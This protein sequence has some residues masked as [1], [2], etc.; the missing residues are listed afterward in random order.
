MSFC[1]CPLVIP[2][3]D[4]YSLDM[5]YPS[6]SLWFADS[7]GFTLLFPRL[8][9]EVL[10]HVTVDVLANVDTGSWALSLY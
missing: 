7:F 3:S 6:G 5:L 9:E 1:G 2:L 4:P 10:I 8:S